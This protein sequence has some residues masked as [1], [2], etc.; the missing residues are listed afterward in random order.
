ME[1]DTGSAQPPSLNRPEPEDHGALQG[2]MPS[3]STQDT[4]TASGQQ[5]EM[6]T[7]ELSSESGASESV[8]ET[9]RAM[10]SAQ[11]QPDPAPVSVMLE[12]SNHGN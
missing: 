5:P 12:S 7:V 2:V 6:N 8:S 11:D 9:E 1:I 10:Q 3:A 4:V